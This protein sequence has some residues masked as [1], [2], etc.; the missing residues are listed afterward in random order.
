M[1]RIRY[2]N[3]TTPT[4][5]PKE[6]P[7]PTEPIRRDLPIERPETEPKAPPPCQPDEPFETCRLPQIFR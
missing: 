2:S 7:S 5:P 6:K 4:A 3:S 1:I